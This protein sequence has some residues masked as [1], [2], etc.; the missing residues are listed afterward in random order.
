MRPRPPEPKGK[1]DA[2]AGYSFSPPVWDC[3]TWVRPAV[4][5]VVPARTANGPEDRPR[6]R[7]MPAEW[8]KIGWRAQEGQG[9]RP[10]GG[11]RQTGAEHGLGQGPQREGGGRPGPPHTAV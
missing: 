2:M 10:G 7:D 8:D 1:L 11:V 5:G 9:P 4:A 3:R 6:E